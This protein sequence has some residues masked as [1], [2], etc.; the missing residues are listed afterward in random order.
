MSTV[1]RTIGLIAFFAW[2][3][4]LFNVWP[5]PPRGDVLPLE[6]QWSMW[7]QSLALT[8][9]G[10]CAAFLAFRAIKLWWLA[11]LLTSGVILLLNLPAMISDISHATS[12]NAWLSVL[13]DNTRPTFLYFLV[14]VPLYHVAVVCGT[15]VY[16]V[17]ALIGRRNANITIA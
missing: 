4:Y 17:L 14:V 10:L 6:M 8:A 9:L 15:F 1:P 2:A 3:H 12:F 5:L 16:G 7:W 11:I 13:R